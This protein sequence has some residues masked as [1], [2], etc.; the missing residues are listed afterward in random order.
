MANNQVFPLLTML[1]VA[2]PAPS[3]VGHTL[4]PGPHSP[5]RAAG[6]DPRPLGVTSLVDLDGNSRSSTVFDVGAYF[7]AP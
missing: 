7:Q 4:H 2:D 5:T 6:T 3:P 1:D